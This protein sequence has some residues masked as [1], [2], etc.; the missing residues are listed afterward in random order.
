MRLRC[1][2]PE[3]LEEIKTEGVVSDGQTQK[4]IDEAM[5]TIA[6]KH[7]GVF[8]GMGRAKV[9]PIDIQMKPVAHPTA[10]PRRPI[11]MQFREPFKKKMEYLKENGLVEGPLEP[12]ECT[13]WIHNPVI[14]KKSWSSKEIRINIDTKRMNDQ[15][16]KTKMPIPTPEELCHELEGSDRFSA[17]D[18]RDAFFHF[19]LTKKAQE[20]FKFHRHDGLY[21]FLVIVMGTAPTSGE[22]HAAMSKILEG[23]EGVLVIKDDILVHGKGRAHDANLDACLQRLFN[24]GIRLR[25]EKSKRSVALRL[26]PE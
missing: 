13:G 3:I 10:Q 4:E 9:N 7:T 16:V 14:T 21:R 25:K 8:E 5:E 12:K 18:C 20:L 17:V 1:I 23:L 6:R 24:F 2:T 15:L 11:I 26:E 22:C 19:L